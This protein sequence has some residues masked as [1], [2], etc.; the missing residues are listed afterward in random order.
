[1]GESH[2]AESEQERDSL[3]SDSEETV[4]MQKVVH[5]SPMRI[6]RVCVFG[7]RDR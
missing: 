4:A 1:M 7:S 6:Q 5:G 2:R 3:V